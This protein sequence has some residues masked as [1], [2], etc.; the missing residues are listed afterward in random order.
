MA[1]A[2]PTVRQR[3]LG[4]RLR[5]LRAGLGF[6]VDDVAK[7]LLCSATKISRIET[8]SRR[9]SLRDVRDL[10]QIYGVSEEGAAD[11][12]GLARQAREPGWWTRYDDLDLGPYPGLAQEATALTHF[13][14]YF[15][16]GLLQTE[17]YARTIIK[18][19]V[20][21]INPKVLDDRVEARLRRQHLLEPE[22]R[23]RFRSL[24]DE[25]ALRRHV[26]GP[27]VMSAQLSKILQVAGEEKA[28]VQVIP[29]R[30]GAHASADSNFTI[31]EFPDTSLPDLVYVEGLINNLLLERPA[32]LARYREALEYLRDS[33]LSPRDSLSLIA[34]IRDTHIGS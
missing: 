19:V 16:H 28:T 22:N 2:N 17:D 32:E 24:M 14:M 6:T 33:A 7:K 11:F 23:P 5:E 27:A 12:M 34:E 29:F 9:A 30:S 21:K 25:G 18:A 4:L 8:G 10:C 26:G 3:E 31:L 13:S 20:P 1:E 15:V